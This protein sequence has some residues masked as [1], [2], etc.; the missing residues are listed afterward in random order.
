M[1]ALW[2]RRNSINVQK[3]LWALD[4][5][6]LAYEHRDAGGD[7]GRLDEPAFRAMNPHG[8][9]PVV[10]DEGGALWESNA[11]VRYLCGRYSPDVLAPPDPLARAQADAWM[12]WTATIL[13]P[14][15]MNLFWG[16]YR[17][18]EAQRNARRN[19]ALVADCASA[20]AS[21][22]LQLQTRPFVAGQTL[23]M[24]DIPAGTLMFRYFGMEIER[25]EAPALEAWRNRLAARPAYREHVMRPFEELFGRLAY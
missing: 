2:G 20:I 13:Q 21:L 14:A 25:P 9:V 15:I 1:I 6:D 17:T 4:E 5:L 22:D 10:E 24:A 11:I 18:P 16:F 8:R 12:D 23:T 7:A 3:V 19:G